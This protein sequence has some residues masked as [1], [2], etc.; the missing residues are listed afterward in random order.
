MKIDSDAPVD[1]RLN[2]LPAAGAAS[3]PG[4]DF[5]PQPG[6]SEHAAAAEPGTRVPS[7]A[8][9][10]DLDLADW[11]V[12]LSAA[13]ARLRMVVGGIS[14]RAEPTPAQVCEG[15]LD[16]ANSLE[17]I[18]MTLRHELDYRQRQAIEL[19]DART[20]LAQ[21]RADIVGGRAVEQCSE[22][23]A[24]HDHLT[25]L[26]NG[27][28]FRQRLAHALAHD[29]FDRQALAVVVI[30]L[31]GL[32]PAGDDEV[33]GTGDQLLRIVAS[34][35]SRALRGS[36]MVSH[37]GGDEMACML[38]GFAGQA[39]L[40]HLACKLFDTV[41]A[42]VRIGM[43]TRVVRPS[44]GITLCPVERGTPEAVIEQAHAAMAR[45]RVCQSGYAFHDGALD[46]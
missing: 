12:L 39:A 33:T 34:R 46:S 36:D 4:E 31:E 16:C 41:A 23:R 5:G 11:E 25:L 14:G 24:L 21:L 6:H 26:P 32:R 19:F 37:M 8:I 28:Y 1:S 27:H 10:T 13:T 30:G 38:P 29:T 44:I 42:P 9:P 45:A 7:R 17:Q 3:L 15:V 22:H 43:T 18:H 20:A 35:L 40:S 2:H